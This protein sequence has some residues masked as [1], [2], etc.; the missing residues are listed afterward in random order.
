LLLIDDPEFVPEPDGRWRM[1]FPYESK[2]HSLK[3]TD[4]LFRERERRNGKWVICVSLGSVYKDDHFGLVAMAMPID[5]VPKNVT[6][7]RGDVSL[8][9]VLS[10]TAVYQ[11]LKEWRRLKMLETKRPAYT[12]FPDVTLTELALKRP[13][14]RQDLLGV[15]GMGPVRV[16]EFGGEILD[17]I[18]Q[19][20]SD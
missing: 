3:V 9:E 17:V 13:A 4:L 10:K 1:K 15:F 12:F 11:A 14:T 2:I 6:F 18:R 8:P 16:A 20:P 5:E 19:V 7:N